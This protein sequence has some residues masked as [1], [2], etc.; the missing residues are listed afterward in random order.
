M[1]TKVAHISDEIHEMATKYCSDNGLRLKDWVSGLIL[2]SIDERAVPV[3][4]PER[5]SNFVPVTKIDRK[6]DVSTRRILTVQKTGDEPWS[7]APFWAVPRFCD[8]E[9]GDKCEDEDEDECC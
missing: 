4:E 7:R 5:E 8:E 1:H 6:K 2:K 3:R 9:S